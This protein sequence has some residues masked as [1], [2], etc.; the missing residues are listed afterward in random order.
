MKKI[1]SY[2]FVFVLML[3]LVGCKKKADTKSECEK[4]NHTPT[5]ATCTEPSKCSVCGIELQSAKGHSWVDA[6]YVNPKTCSVCGT[7]E[8]SPL[9]PGIVTVKGSKLL[10][11][12]QEATYVLGFSS[13]GEYEAFSSDDS[14][15]KIESIDGNNCVVKALAIGKVTLTF[16]ALDSSEKGQIE[17]NIQEAVYNITYEN[18]ANV[19]YPENAITSYKVTDLPL[20]LP[21]PTKEGFVFLGWYAVEDY[22]NSLIDEFDTSKLWTEIPEGT[23]ANLY[24]TP[25]FG[26]PRV[27]ITNYESPVIDLNSELTLNAVKK[28]LPANLRDSEL[29]WSSD[30]EDVLVVD[31][32]GKISPKSA[33]Y[34]VVKVAV[35]DDERYNVTLGLSVVD[36]L[37]VLDEAINFIIKNNKDVAIAKNITVTGYQFKYTH[38]L[39]S[40]VN[41][42]G[43]F[44]HVVNESYMVP[45]GA[46]NRPGDVYP[47]YYVTVHDTASSAE[48]ANSL[49]HAKYV[50]NGGGGTSW[51]YSSGDT[52]IYHHIPD[53]ERAYHAGDGKQQYQLFDTGLTYNP[54]G[55]GKV[56]ISA[57]GYFEIDGVKTLI[58]VPKKPSG[59][60]PLTSEINDAGIELVVKNNKYYLGDT[61]WSDTYGYVSNTG[62]NCNSIGIE[63]MVDKGSDLYMTWQKTAKLVAHLLVDNNLDLND[64]KPH[65]YFSGKNCPQT[66][67]DNGLWENF[68]KLVE[69]EYEYLTKYSDCQIEITSLD[70]QYINS[71]GRI[72]KQDKADHYASYQVTITKDGVSKTITLTVKIPGLSHNYR[73]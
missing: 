27:E 2:L 18:K 71:R 43:F 37:N 3:S 53:N 36:D 28:Y 45:S 6:D 44:E 4:G 14:I 42:F 9:E 66:M 72:I 70:P 13:E 51:H 56:T 17:I 49:A 29:V 58:A 65:H 40:S 23:K 61:W 68:L 24:I 15:V 62:G 25:I 5:Q 38:K 54:E 64:V 10:Q 30:N 1:I 31:Q 11:V 60:I 46:S 69:A 20:T 67:R 55:L 32:S 33:G 34:A 47:K 48:G 39:Y 7:T 50:Q 16:I 52:G 35:K 41:N 21:E 73:G 8:G 26:Y 22:N 12:D 57:D 19:V 63:T 59:A